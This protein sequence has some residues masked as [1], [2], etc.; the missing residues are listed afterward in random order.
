[1][2]RTYSPA[3]SHKVYL[4][5][6]RVYRE[7]N[8]RNI[9]TQEGTRFRETDYDRAFELQSG[10]C[11]ICTRSASELKRRLAV[12]HDHK[13]GRFRGLLCATCNTRLGAYENVARTQRFE[14][15]LKG[16]I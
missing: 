4:R 6:V 7:Y 9:L 2:P 12:D 3:Y 1:V 10:R 16:E 13:T 14:A 15:Y 11:K 8:W 5:K